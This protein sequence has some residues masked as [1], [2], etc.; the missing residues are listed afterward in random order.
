[1]IFAE[2]LENERWFEIEIDI[3]WNV[4]ELGGGAWKPISD[5][6][7]QSTLEKVDNFEQQLLNAWETA[8]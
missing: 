1:M 2:F 6:G 8:T 7:R 5:W 3:T 4:L